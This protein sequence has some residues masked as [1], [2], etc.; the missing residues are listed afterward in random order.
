MRLENVCAAGGRVAFAVPGFVGWIIEP[1]AAA[2]VER[3]AAKFRAMPGEVIGGIVR[4]FD[5][6]RKAEEGREHW[7][8]IVREAS[9]DAADFEHWRDMAEAVEREGVM[10]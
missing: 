8:R 1:D 5:A 3:Y 4:R 7:R 10:A 6:M 9:D 2:I